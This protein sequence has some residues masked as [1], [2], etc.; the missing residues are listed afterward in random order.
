MW[1]LEDRW[2]FDMSFS[3]VFNSVEAAW[4]IFLA[5][6]TAMGGHR[7]RG[8]TARLQ[9][10]FV[11]GFTAFGISDVIEVYTGAWWRPVSLL[12]LKAACLVGLAVS[13]YWLLR[14]RRA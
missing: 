8:M 7:V 14:N 9:G 10:V 13:I 3:S 4:W 5:A 6:L 2:L 11:L 12:M 1:F